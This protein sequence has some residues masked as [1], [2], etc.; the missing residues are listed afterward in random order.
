MKTVTNCTTLGEA[1]HF[2]MILEATGIPSFIPDEMSAGI[3][4]HH[5]FSSSSGVRLQVADEHADE[6]ETIIQE[7]RQKG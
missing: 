2:K 1:Q 5:F 6:A 4:P 7:L 3:A